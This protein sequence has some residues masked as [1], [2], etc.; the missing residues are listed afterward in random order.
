MSNLE[1]IVGNIS[2]AQYVKGKRILVQ[3]WVDPQVSRSMRFPD[4]MTVAT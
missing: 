1:I 2:C 4:F 3:G